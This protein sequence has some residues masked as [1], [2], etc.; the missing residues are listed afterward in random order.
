M[1]EIAF[2]AISC[3]VYGFPV[4]R[5]ARIAVHEV[6]KFPVEGTSLERAYLVC[7][8]DEIT[9]AYRRALEQGLP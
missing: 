2:P 1:R 4:E 8:G 7:F 3:G 5:A 6:R 9:R